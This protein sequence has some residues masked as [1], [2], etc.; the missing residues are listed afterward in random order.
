M[1]T[2]DII[3]LILI[4]LGAISGFVTG[5]L[6]QAATLFG[7]IAGL[8]IAKALYLTVAEKLCP[9]ITD[10]MTVAQIVAFVA[11]WI[12]VPLVCTLIAGVLSGFLKALSLGWINQLLGFLAGIVMTILVLSVALNV[13]DF[14]DSGGGL[15]SRTAKEQSL[16]Y[17][18]IRDLISLVFPTIQGVF[19]ETSNILT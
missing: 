14:V 6:K 1:T 4:G 11:I 5:I 13:L 12:L 3:F 17:Y 7:L 15:I 8:F 10:S 16:L 2:I 19:T 18:P 9:A